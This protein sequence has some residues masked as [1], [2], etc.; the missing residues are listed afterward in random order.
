MKTIKFA[1]G[2]H[3]HQPVD[4]FGFIFEKAYKKSYEPF[5]GV[6]EKHPGIKLSLHYS[7]P[8]LDWLCDQRPEF[9]AR[10]KQLAQS[11]QVEILTGGYF[12]PILT[13][14]PRED[15]KGQVGL[16]T[17]HIKECF[18]VNPRGA[19]LAERVWQPALAGIFNDLGVK[20]TVLDDY[21][22]KQARVSADRFFGHHSIKGAGDFSIFA[23]IK[24]LR[25]TMPFR[26]LQVTMDFFDKLRGKENV[27]CVTFADDGEKFGFWPYTY[28][29]VYKKGWLD[30]FFTAIEKQDWIETVTFSEALSKSRSLGE[31]EVPASSY[32][33]MIEW[34]GGNF[35]NF[36]NKYPESGLMRNR[37]LGVSEHLRDS[38]NEEAA[39]ELYKSQSNCAYWHG[40]FG[41]VY[42]SYLRHSVYN[43]LIK[44]EKILEGEK[45]TKNTRTIKFQNGT[46]EIIR[47]QN[48][49]L[50]IFIN[51]EY[52]G[53]IIEIDYKP[54]AYNLVDTMSRRYEPYHEKLKRNGKYNL[55]TLKKKIDD[56]SSIDLYE[57]LGVRGR[58]LDRLLNYDSYR[59]V[60]C[61]CHVMDAGKTLE[62]FVKSFHVNMDSSGL[63]GGFNHMITKEDGCLVVALE[64]VCR[65]KVDSK[66]PRELHLRKRIV[67]GN[68]SGFQITFE[69]ENTSNE[70]IKCI[71]GIEHN[72]S[73]EDRNF[74]RPKKRRKIKS[75]LLRDRYS[76]LA[77]MQE[78]SEG[79]DFWS[80][81]VYTL[82]VT[83]KGLGK[84]FQ[85]TSFLFHKKISLASSEKFSLKTNLVVSG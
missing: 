6:L 36:F 47:A 54:L 72:W 69:L 29:W 53:S 24:K 58:N 7:G 67:L 2:L 85:E 13:M 82:N 9:I 64:R 74:M 15:A 1:M 56:E 20:Y 34:C 62:D 60:A 10:V 78:F 84:T 39:R 22:L 32:S 51:P 57:V 43:H 80:F 28:D 63:L 44:A 55:E 16:L 4:N 26:D 18:G 5:L 8:L 52:A 30:K 65:V 11:G 27:E 25:Y 3:C 66:T 42:T 19:W 12:E 17:R 81:P 46:D 41:G 21:H 37:M 45:K 48:G 49:F 68:D 83:E 75:V 40:V 79:L 14:I 31:I 71:F 61:L 76:G 70:P 35:D 38:C 77:L 23:A 33:E 59:K 73:I 50:T